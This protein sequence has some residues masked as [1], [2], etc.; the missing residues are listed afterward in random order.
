MLCQVK[1][2]ALA[3]VK[4]YKGQTFVT[5]PRWWP[6]VPSTLNVIAED[7]RLR[8]WPNCEMQKIGC[9]MRCS[10]HPNPAHCHWPS[11]SDRA[12]FQYV[13]SMEID[14]QGRMWV[15]DSGITSLWKDNYDRAR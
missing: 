4:V 12:A 14:T 3:G 13:Q 5:V 11:R 15:I 9:V 8:P 6:G 1:N 7:G 10:A 2:N